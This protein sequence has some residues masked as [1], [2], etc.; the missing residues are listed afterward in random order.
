VTLT[1]ARSQ[2][3]KEPREVPS[4]PLVEKVRERGI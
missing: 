1:P 2:R 3:E 4:P